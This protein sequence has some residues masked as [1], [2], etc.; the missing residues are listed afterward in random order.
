MLAAVIATSALAVAPVRAVAE[1]FWLS[2]PDLCTADIGEIEESGAI[3][4]TK[5]GISSHDI[6]C[7]WP[8]K[9]GEALLQGEWSVTTRASCTSSTGVWNAELEIVQQNDGTV[10]VFQESGGLSPIQFYRCD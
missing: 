1:T 9:A 3:Y 4:L 6:D 8:L 7:Q 5:H 2:A 10:Q